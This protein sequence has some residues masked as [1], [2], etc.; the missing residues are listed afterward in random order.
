MYV[1]ISDVI[2]RWPGENDRHFAEYFFSE[3][4]IL[5]ETYVVFY[6]NLTAV[7]CQCYTGQYVAIDSGN[8]DA[9]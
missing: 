5:R 4:I 7:Y 2:K 6:S 1:H 3:C 8:F 9:S